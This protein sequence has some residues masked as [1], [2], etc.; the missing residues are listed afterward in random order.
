MAN[1]V[2]KYAAKKMLAK[3]LDQYK[4]K[5][6]A[7][8]Y[9]PYYEYRINPRTGKEKKYKKQIPAYIP[10]H[11]ANVLARVRKT[12]YR[13]DCSL[14]S[15]MGIRFGIGSVIGLVPAIGDA[16]DAALALNTVRKCKKVEG[17][18]PGG[19]LLQMLFWVFIDFV[20]G[21][22]P[23][24]GDL[25]D[26]SIKANSK[27][28]RLLEEHLDAKYKPQEV[29]AREKSEREQAKRQ[30]RPYKPPAPATVYEDMSDEE[31]LPM[32]EDRRPHGGPGTGAAPMQQPVAQPPVAA[33]R[34][35]R[36]G[37]PKRER[38]GRR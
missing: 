11:D 13:L 37:A 29:K 27:N 33:G 20:V 24:V 38:S 18:L 10:E 25:L 22:V 34:H 3:Q 21:L 6:P 5:S 1:I 23:F 7:G 31:S 9:D 30:S 16:A 17:G 2:A 26:A 36:S 19:V 4:D 28:C 32:Y 35:E 12:A 15:F 8:Q 14:F